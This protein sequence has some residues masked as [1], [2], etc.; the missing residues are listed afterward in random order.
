MASE[1]GVRVRGG[2]GGCSSPSQGSADGLHHRHSSRERACPLLL[3]LS[4]PAA[5]AAA[6]GP[7]VLASGLRLRFSGNEGV[8]P[9]F[10]C[11]RHLGLLL[12]FVFLF[13]FFLAF[14]LF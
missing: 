14:V 12:P 10:L 4:A 1:P 5:A 3:A 8:D 13:V 2:Q 9:F 11:A 6:R 7:G